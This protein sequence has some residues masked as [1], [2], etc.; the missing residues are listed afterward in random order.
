MPDLE[1]ELRAGLS[2]A[3][4]LVTVSADPW[5]DY[6]SRAGRHS[7]TRRRLTVAISIA[8]IAASTAVIVIGAVLLGSAGGPAHHPASSGNRKVVVLTPQTPLNA[9]GLAISATII[10]RRLSGL[11]VHN[12]QVVVVGDSLEAHIPA[13]AIATLRTVAQ[14]RGVLRLRQAM[15]FAVGSSASPANT[16]PQAAESPTL[17]PAFMKTFGEW[18]CTKPATRNPTRGKD[19]AGDYIIACSTGGDIKYLLAPAAVDGTQIASA[20]ASLPTQSST[21]WVVEVDFR[22]SAAAAWQAL[23]RKAYN[24]N[25][26]QPSSTC[27]PPTGCNMVATTL[28]G[29]VLSA[30]YII[31]AGGIPGGRA[32]I[33]GSFTRVSANNLADIL[34]YGALPQVFTVG[35]H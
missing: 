33:S 26:G 24:V 32:Q 20:A 18:D 30:P 1:S 16:S 31:T 6:R 2:D 9:G 11:G 28:D 25:R 35:S 17:T 19:R 3:A 13:S 5:A 12:P 4:N 22:N 23:T 15:T 27:G 34:K 8:A 21:S 14:T 29:V 10:E 7:P